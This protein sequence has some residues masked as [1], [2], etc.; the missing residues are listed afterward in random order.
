MARK[1]IRAEGERAALPGFAAD[2]KPAAD[3]ARGPAGEGRGISADALR[4]LAALRDWIGDDVAFADLFG[5][6]DNA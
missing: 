4:S 1:P 6:A 3:A 2:E 5:G